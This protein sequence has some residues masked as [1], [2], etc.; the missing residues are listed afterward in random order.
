MTVNS[1]HF[2][3]I[4]IVQ[5]KLKTERVNI[6]SSHS[7]LLFDFFRSLVLFLFLLCTRENLFVKI[8]FS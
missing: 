5:S 4:E 8:L 3:S 6:L 7:S 1:L 2:N